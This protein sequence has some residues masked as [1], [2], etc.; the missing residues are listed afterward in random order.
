MPKGPVGKRE[1]K[2]PKKK[3]PKKLAV[4]AP[5]LGSPQVEVVAKRRKPR[6]EEE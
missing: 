5:I 3:D 4:S 1:A 6:E 2:K